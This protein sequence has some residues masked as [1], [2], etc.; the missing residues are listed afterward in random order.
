MFSFLYFTLKNCWLINTLQH[1]LDLE[2][3]NL[4]VCVPCV[5]WALTKNQFFEIKPLRGWIGVQH[6]FVPLEY[7]LINTQ[8]QCL[9][10]EA[11]NLGESIPSVIQCPV[12]MPGE[13]GGACCFPVVPR[14]GG[15]AQ[16]RMVNGVKEV[17]GG[18]VHWGGAVWCWSLVPAAQ[19]F[20]TFYSCNCESRKHNGAL[21]LQLVTQQY[22][23]TVFST[24]R[25]QSD[26]Q[27]NN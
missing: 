19:I 18:M 16:G 20:L 5:T 26:L 9:D 13:P 3:L 25:S 22:L 15:G 24:K 2:A 6:I 27:K 11:W 10:L 1:P 23:Y 12:G 21:L 4:G 17:H 8:P 14:S 7:W